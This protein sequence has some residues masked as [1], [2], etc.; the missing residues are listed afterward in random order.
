MAPLTV[1][2]PL[3]LLLEQGGDQVVTML[4]P[5]K[6]L[7]LKQRHSPVTPVQPLNSLHLSFSA[8]RQELHVR[9]VKLIPHLSNL[10]VRLS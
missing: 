10:L 1:A 7:L 9:L 4:E 5:S 6:F 2:Y 8:H 3:V